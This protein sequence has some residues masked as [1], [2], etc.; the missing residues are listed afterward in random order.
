M[1]LFTNFAKFKADYPRVAAVINKSALTL[2]IPAFLMLC[3]MDWALAKTMF[4]WSLFGIVLSGVAA[5][6]SLITFPHI[7][8]DRLMASV[9]DGRNTGAGL[10]VAAIIMFVGLLTLSLVLWAKA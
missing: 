7:E 10:V 1:N 4:Q 6:I 3:Y 8:L 5:M 9:L 2:M